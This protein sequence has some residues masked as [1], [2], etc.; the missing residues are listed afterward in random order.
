MQQLDYE[1]AESTTALFGGNSNW[2]GPVWF[3]V[4]YLVVEA[5]GRLHDGLG[6]AFTVECPAGSGRRRTL[7]EVADEI[8]DRLIGLFLVGPDGTRP[9]F[10]GA[11]RLQHDPAWSE[12]L[13]IHE[14]FHGDNGA[15]LGA[16]HQTGWTALVA[17]LIIERAPAET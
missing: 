7:A 4:N 13:A 10:G 1:P 6:E 9:C 5:L 17:V 8:S 12:H 11:E 16:S 3:P 2:R 14:Y 15:G